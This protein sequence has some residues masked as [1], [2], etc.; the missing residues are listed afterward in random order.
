MNCKA[1][2]PGNATE[3]ATPS[4]FMAMS[5]TF[6]SKASV[7]SSDAPSGSFTPAIRYILSCTGMNPGGT[8]LNIKPV[9]ASNS[10]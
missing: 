4:V 8:T 6:C 10:A 2:K 1:F 7:R 3:C 9:P 5:V